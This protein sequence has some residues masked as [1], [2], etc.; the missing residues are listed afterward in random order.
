MT[1]I[2]SKPVY[3]NGVKKM[4]KLMYHYTNP[5]SMPFIRA[6][7]IAPGDVP[8]SSTLGFKAVNLTDDEIFVNQQGW[9]GDSTKWRGRIAIVIPDEYLHLLKTWQE[10]CN[11]LDIP[12][13]WVD[14]LNDAGD[15]QSDQ[16]CVFFG[17]V[18]FD[19]VVAIVTD[20]TDYIAPTTEHGQG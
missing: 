3:R 11:W 13:K 19:W 9:A 7:G 8:T 15:G 20:E 14:N 4:S 16:W 17:Q 5:A 1:E 18:P 10:V 6:L 12:K 2:E